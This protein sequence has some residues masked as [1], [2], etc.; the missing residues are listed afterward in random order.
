MDLTRRAFVSQLGKYVAGAG[1]LSLLPKPLHAQAHAIIQSRR[2][3]PGDRKFRSEAVERYIESICRTIRDPVL[4]AIFAN[5]F[6]NTLDTTVQPSTF[7]GKPDTAVLTGDIAAMWLRDSSAQVWPYLRLASKDR[8]LHQLLEGVIRRQTRCLLIDPYANCFMANLS[9]P[10]LEGSRKDETVMKQG[11]GERKYELD[12]LCYPIRLSHGYWKN[13]GDTSPFDS[14]WKLAMQTV[15]KTMRVEQRK[16]G[17][18]PYRFQRAALNPTDSLVNGIGNPLR[19]VGLIA[20]AFRPA[21]DACILPFLVPA[22]LFAVT[23]LRQLATMCGAI[24]RDGRMANEASDLA[25]E[26][27]AALRK[28]AIVPTA[29]GTIWAYEIDGYGNSILM[30]DANAPGLL[31]LPYLDSSPD[32]ALYARTR[33]FVWSERNPW[34]FRG[35]AGEGIGG[36]H[37]GRDSIWP[38]SQIIYALTSDSDV[39]IRTMIRTL[40]SCA[41]AT[42]FIHESYNRNDSAIFTRAWF[43]W[44]NTLFGELIAKTARRDAGLL[45]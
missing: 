8:S 6:P 21:D 9:A 5:C 34:F 22:N 38:M 15:L 42:G 28:H 45:E 39:E 13:T 27:E 4:A 24:L 29:A 7:E 12:S 26:V 19:P 23:S 36:P 10:P 18:G 41:A 1:T 37:I 43:A 44:A 2:P 20:S 25:N 14:A 17:Q 33:S 16:D 31:S 40:K 3:A 30:D 32:A 11:V 35:S